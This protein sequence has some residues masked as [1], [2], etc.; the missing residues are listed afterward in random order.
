MS[1]P[2]AA[3]RYTGA[4][5]MPFAPPHF[6]PGA[7]HHG[8]GF[9]RGC[10]QPSGQ[11]GCG[12]RECRKESKELEFT[13]AAASAKADTTAARNANAD[14]SGLHVLG[15]SS[16]NMDASAA[17]A[18]A[19]IIPARLSVVV[20]A[21]KSRSNMPPSCRPPNPPSWS[22][23]PISKAPCWPGRRS[24]NPAP[25]TRSRKTSSRPIQAPR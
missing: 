7:H 5:V 10:G 18:T 14:T 20:A 17:A 2:H 12:C 22:P 25:T 6:R 4:R 9:C 8:P 21:F 11:C 24:S 15:F 16:L 1:R 13:G 19:R 3:P 23:W